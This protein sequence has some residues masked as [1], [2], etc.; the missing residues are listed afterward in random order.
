MDKQQ[1]NLEKMH[2]RHQQN[3]KRFN[4]VIS[5]LPH[6]EERV[7]YTYHHDYMRQNTRCFAGGSRG[8]V[9]MVTQNEPSHVLYAV[10]LVQILKAEA[11]LEDLLDLSL[12]EQLYCKEAMRI[13]D[14]QVEFWEALNEVTRK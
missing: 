14:E 2:Q 11:T 1:E 5:K 12:E 8:D 10:A 9:A 6:S 3:I 13:T 7:P 4:G